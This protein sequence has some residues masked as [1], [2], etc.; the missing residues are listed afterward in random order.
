M[1][2]IAAARNSP[3]APQGKGYEIDKANEAL[4]RFHF[5]QYVGK[6]QARIP[7]ANRDA[8]KYVIADSYEIPVLVLR[9]SHPEISRNR[10]FVIQICFDNI[11]Q[12]KVQ[13]IVD[14]GGPFV[15]VYVDIGRI[16]LARIS[17]HSC[18]KLELHEGKDAYALIKTVAVSLGASSERQGK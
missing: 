2:V 14:N 7:A 8:L 17:R 13:T 11:F 10:K 4:I 12:G 15:D 3:A 9:A 6:L 16:L 18:Y 1:A 5:E